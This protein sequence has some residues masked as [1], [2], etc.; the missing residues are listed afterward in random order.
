VVTWSDLSERLEAD[1]RRDCRRSFVG[2]PFE[3]APPVALLLLHGTQI[4][5]LASWSEAASAV[6]AA[7]VLSAVPEA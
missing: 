6:A 1:L 7:R 4:D 3:L 5:A 2:R